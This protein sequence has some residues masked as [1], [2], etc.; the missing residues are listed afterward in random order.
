MMRISK[1]A[2]E[3]EVRTTHWMMP[4]MA[5]P[6]GNIFGGQ[7]MALVDTIAYMC[8]ARYAAN[9]VCVTAAMDRLDLHEPVH[10]G[11]LLN[12]I[13]RVTYAGRSSMEI[14]INVYAENLE[15]SQLRLT[16]T[17]YLTMVSLNDGTSATVPQ[18]I[19]RTS[20]DKARYLQAKM[21][22]EMGMRYRQERDRFVDEFAMMDDAQLD[23]LLAGDHVQE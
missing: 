15:T 23:A 6:M 2:D 21:R 13:A 19:C 3:T 18:L 11:E 7:I 4:E 12:L 8:A 16:H 17:C 22:R 5:N 20:V 1:Y 10:V 9:R 14:E